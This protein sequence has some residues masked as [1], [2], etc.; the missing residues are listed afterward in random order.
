MQDCVFCISNDLLKVPIAHDSEL[1]YFADMQPMEGS[2]AGLAITKRHVETPFEISEQEWQ[3]L[4]E[5]L[6]EFKSFLDSREKPQGYS[7]GWNIYPTGGQT[8]P[9]AHLH[10]AARYDDEELAGRG[11]RYFFKPER[12]QR[13]SP[14]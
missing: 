1:W 6:P 10:I 12:N 7:M 2:N 3:A 4:H 14:Q 11:I 8:V 13:K 9:H 5:L